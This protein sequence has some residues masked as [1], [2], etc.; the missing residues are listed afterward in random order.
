MK[1]IGAYL[2]GICRKMRTFVPDFRTYKN[3]L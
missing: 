3:L 2:D 1:A